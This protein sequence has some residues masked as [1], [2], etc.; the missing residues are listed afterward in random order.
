MI[1]EISI[2]DL[3]VI[4]EAKLKFGPGLTVL[5]GETGA[6]KTMVLTAVGLLLG[7]RSDTSAIRQG[8]DQAFVQGRWQ[9]NQHQKANELVVEAGGNVDAGELIV[10]RSVARDGRSRSAIGGAGAPVNLLASLGEQLVAVHGQSDQIRLKSGIAQR[11]A[12]DQFS[13]VA[14]LLGKYRDVFDRWKTLEARLE[15]LRSAS[16]S[17]ETEIQQLQEATAELDRL[18][19]EAGEDEALAEKA[20]RLTHSE[21]LRIA[22]S[23]AHELLSSENTDT[24]AIALVG[25]AR[26]VLEAASVN[27][28]ELGKIAETLRQLGFQLGE[29]AAALNGYLASSEGGGAAELEQVQQRRADLGAA[30]RKYGPTLAE[31][32]AFQETA[33]KKLLELDNSDE[34]IA[35]LTLERDGLF[36]EVQDLAG[37]VTAVRKHAA[38]RLE[39]AVTE[40]LKSLAMGGATLVVSVTE[41]S[42]YQLHG[43]DL[44][45]IQLAAYPGAEPRPIG[46]GAS[47]GELSRIMLAIEVV[48]AKTE[49]ALTFIFDE[50]DAGVG[51]AAAIEVG[52][53]LAQLA[54]VAQVIVV[55]HLGQVA[56]FANQHLRVLK[57]MSDQYTASDVVELQGEDRVEEIARMLSGMAESDTARANARELMIKAKE[58]VNQ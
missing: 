40:E 18:K 15:T 11:E 46:K 21:E 22:A 48:L 8:Q 50:V 28:P 52:K 16:S 29:N 3:G 47:G 56:A 14:T 54:K 32:I 10:N 19:P 53:R 25:K 45:S 4:A 2:R 12:L 43:A 7:E 5:T 57:T 37:Q 27:D 36:A 42:E 58:F 49:Q 23:E 34:Q 38:L 13:G 41:T 20:Q 30:M 44:V 55:T 6:G 9:I 33:G 24:D 31:V 35:A 17:R 1:E 39:T 51:G 26:R